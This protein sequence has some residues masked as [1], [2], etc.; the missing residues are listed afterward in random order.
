MSKPVAL[1]LLNW[2]TPVHTANCILSLQQ[3]CDEQLFDILIADN[4]STDNSLALLKAQFP[5][6]VY[7]DNKE[8]LGFAEGNNRGLVYSINNGYTYSLVMNT[9]TLVDEDMV[10]CLKT[11]LDNYLQ[12][13]AVQPAIYWMH[14][15][16]KI[17]NGEGSFN[18]FLGTTKSST[19][20]PDT[21]TYKTVEWVTG[22]CMMIR[23]SALIMSGLFNKQFFLYYEDVELSYRLRDCGYELHYLPSCKMYHEAG[24][25]AKVEKK[26]GFL[27]PVIHYYISRNHIWFLRRYALPAYYPVN[28][29]YNGFYYLALLAYFILRGRKEKASYLIKGLKEG[30]FASNN[31]IWSPNNI[32]IR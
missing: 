29:I 5:N 8:N 18:A 16:T 21:N 22:C 9:D 23:N 10:T 15:R 25:S 2:N 13:A 11:H 6:L 20:I 31:L 27:S 12:A 1:I 32:S 4:G 3:Y 26:E 28:L 30:I 14:D 7:I 17:W 19:K 24:V